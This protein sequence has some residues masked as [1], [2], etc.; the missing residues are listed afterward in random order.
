MG[1][2]VCECGELQG[3]GLGSSQKKAAVGN[4]KEKRGRVRKELAGEHLQN[5]LPGDKRG[6]QAEEKVS[7]RDCQTRMLL[8]AGQQGLVG[9]DKPGCSVGWM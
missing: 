3:I 7:G 2:C 1:A 6:A 8:P 4:K 9:S 5:R